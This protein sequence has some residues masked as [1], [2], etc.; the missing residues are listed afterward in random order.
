MAVLGKKL[1]AT[2]KNS[3]NLNSALAVSKI[4]IY[5]R[6]QEVIK[7]HNDLKEKLFQSQNLELENIPYNE[8]K[9][10]S[11]KYLERWSEVKEKL[12]KAWTAKPD[13]WDFSL[14]S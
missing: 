9:R 2:K 3:N 6:F 8:M 13:I 11:V 4:K 1:G 7:K 10:K 12:F 14:K 5:K